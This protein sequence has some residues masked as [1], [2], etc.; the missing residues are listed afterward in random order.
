MAAL[1]TGSLMILSFITTAMQ[2]YQYLQDYSADGLKRILIFYALFLF[3]DF[4]VAFIA[5]LLE[6]N[7]DWSLLVGLLL[8]R[9]FYRQLMYSG[10]QIHHYRDSQNG[11]GLGGN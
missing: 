10:D 11:H 5:F 7:E 6:K 1:Q 4:L 9:F 8:Q 3:V 2:K